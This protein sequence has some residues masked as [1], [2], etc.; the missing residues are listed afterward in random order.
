[1][2]LQP[3]VDAHVT[4]TDL[5]VIKLDQVTQRSDAV[6]VLVTE[7]Q[8]IEPLLAARSPD[9]VNLGNYPSLAQRLMHLALQPPTQPRQLVAVAHRPT[10]L[11]D[12]CRRHPCLRQPP[13]PQQVG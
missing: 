11:A 9:R 7:T 13:H 8:I 12:L 10:Q 4:I 6:D 2:S 5:A 1:M 3:A